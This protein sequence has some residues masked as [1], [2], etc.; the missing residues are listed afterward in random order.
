[1]PVCAGGMCRENIKF[2]GG[3][4][5][6]KNYAY[7]DKGGILHVVESR[8]TAEEYT[9]GKVVETEVP[10]AH[11]YPLHEGKDVTMYSLDTAYIGGNALLG[12]GR[13]AKM[14]DIPEIVAL[15]KAC[16]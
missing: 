7:I 12:S 9:T 3:F 5:M 15:Y 10:C 8:K 14:T 1:M 13:R 16:M 4:V 6:K 11:G 2:K